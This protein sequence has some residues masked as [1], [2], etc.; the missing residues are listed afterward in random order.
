MLAC[1]VCV[2]G[3]AAR[4]RNN[5]GEERGR[6]ERRKRKRKNKR[7]KTKYAVAP[8]LFD[9]FLYCLLGV[10]FFDSV[11]E[12]HQRRVSPSQCI[13][14]RE[15]THSLSHPST[16]TMPCCPHTQNR[17]NA[18]YC[19]CLFSSFLP[20]FPPP[21]SCSSPLILVTKHH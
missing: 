14:G 19:T 7:G 3:Q 9:I 6:C 11:L 5:G 8:N 10:Y 2:Q 18:R 16:P 1:V 20:F 13:E 21:H 12:C 15:T 4:R 17:K